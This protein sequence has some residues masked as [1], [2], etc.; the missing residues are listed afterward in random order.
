MNTINFVPEWDGEIFFIN[1]QYCLFSFHFLKLNYNTSYKPKAD[2][3]FFMYRLETEVSSLLCL[4]L[5]A[6][7]KKKQQ[8][9]QLIC[10]LHTVAKTTLVSVTSNLDRINKVIVW[11]LT[12]FQTAF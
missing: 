3:L 9:K 11:S 4:L 1:R 10:F 2:F 12:A 6:W 5:K 8:H 7:K